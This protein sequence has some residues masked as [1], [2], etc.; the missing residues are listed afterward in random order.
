MRSSIGAEIAEVERESAMRQ[1]V[2][3]GQVVR[4]KMKQG[5]ADLHI[6]RMEDVLA[7]LRQLQRG[8]GDDTQ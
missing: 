3:A 4:G 6:S 5:E 1:R 2:Y 8:E 7:S